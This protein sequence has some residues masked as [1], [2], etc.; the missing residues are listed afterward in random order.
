MD[1]KQL[2]FFIQLSFCFLFTLDCN[3]QNTVFQ[4]GTQPSQSEQNT[5]I[6]NV[7]ELGNYNYTN[8]AQNIAQNSSIPIYFWLNKSVIDYSP[9]Y[10]ELNSCV[11][12]INQYFNF[13][14]N[15]RFTLC[16]SSYISDSRFFTVSVYDFAKQQLM[17]DTYR[18]DNAINIY[19]VDLASPGAFTFP[20]ANP[21]RIIVA[22]TI[23][24]EIISHEMGHFFGLAHTFNEW[25]SEL[26]R[27][28]RVFV[29]DKNP[30]NFL[31]G[32]DR[33]KGTPADP[34]PSIFSGIT[35]DCGQ[36][37]ND[38]TS[39]TCNVFDDNQDQLI[40]DYTNIMSYYPCK[41]HFSADQQLFMNT[42]LMKPTR[43]YLLNAN[44][45]PQLANFGLL[46][47]EYII[48]PAL[49]EKKVRIKNAI[50]NFTNSSNSSLT[51]LN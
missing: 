40:P 38:C 2:I 41:N 43:S 6:L 27:V 21:L 26:E 13:P 20:P 50:I 23:D 22:P 34:I 45:E 16:G 14:N 17:Y 32:G 35:V 7:Q 25:N 15:T 8:I 37:L 5:Y 1:S 3:A 28:T 30:P 31:S 18:K 11:E 12:S 46:E 39:G 29:A 42:E 4:C 24:P 49:E 33:L 10:S 44:C 36:Y 9:T 48:L 47:R 51:L 19:I